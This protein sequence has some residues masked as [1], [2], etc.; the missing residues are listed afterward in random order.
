MKNL[1]VIKILFFINIKFYRGG[2]IGR[3]PF[4]SYDWMFG[5]GFYVLLGITSFARLAGSALGDTMGSVGRRWPQPCF[6]TGRGFK[7]PPADAAA[8]IKI[9]NIR[10]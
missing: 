10:F 5:P 8:P 9:D 7:G 3:R 6:V 1:F 2:G 4:K